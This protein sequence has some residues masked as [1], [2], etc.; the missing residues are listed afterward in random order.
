MSYHFM[1]NRVT[2]GFSLKTLLTRPSTCRVGSGA[3]IPAASAPSS[4]EESYK[5]LRAGSA[6]SVLT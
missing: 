4:S 3:I 5:A 2:R 1:L 6:Y